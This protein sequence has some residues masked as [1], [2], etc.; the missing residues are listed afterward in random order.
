VSDHFPGYI[1]FGLKL[2][3]RRKISR[4]L[5]AG[6]FTGLGSI[7]AFAFGLAVIAPGIYLPDGAQNGA[8]ESPAD[9]EETASDFVGSSSQFA[10]DTPSQIFYR[11]AYPEFNGSPE[12]RA[13]P[14]EGL[15]DGSD[16]GQL[17]D[18][19]PVEDGSSAIFRAADAPG[20][21]VRDGPPDQGDSASGFSRAG[22]FGVSRQGLSRGFAGGG[23]NEDAGSVL[24]S[25]DILPDNLDGGAPDPVEGANGPGNGPPLSETAPGNLFPSLLPVV[26]AEGPRSTPGPDLDPFL[27]PPAGLR[28]PP[29]PETPDD[30]GDGAPPSPPD[31]NQGPT[32]DP[33]P[34][35]GLVI[36]SSPVHLSPVREV[37]EPGSL[38]LI[39]LGL[40]GMR[41][42]RRTRRRAKF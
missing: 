22:G 4:S 2:M 36:P 14:S 41:W 23:V 13:N 16:S 9:R 1:L 35:A 24:A 12:R 7:G 42:V 21:D 5:I 26:G 33:V 27:F 28:S 29:A 8:Q 15:A 20:G 11:R 31:A 6:L 40:L 32:S 18:N 17:P 19:D 34:E 30:N 37:P 25:L 39:G 38:G 10:P 3:S